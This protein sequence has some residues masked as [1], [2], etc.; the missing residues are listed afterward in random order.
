VS[1]IFGRQRLATVRDYFRGIFD[2]DDD[3]DDGGGDGGW[4]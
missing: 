3:D 1:Y 2:D 4:I